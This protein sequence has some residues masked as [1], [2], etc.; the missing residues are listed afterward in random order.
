MLIQHITFQSNS[1][2]VCYL[3]IPSFIGFYILVSTKGKLMNMT[4]TDYMDSL[5]PGPK[6]LIPKIGRNDPPT[7]AETTHP[8]IWPKR[9]KLKR[10]RAETTRIP[11]SVGKVS[12]NTFLLSCIPVRTGSL[13]ASAEIF[14]ECKCNK[15][16]RNVSWLS[17]TSGSPR[18]CCIRGKGLRG[19]V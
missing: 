7:K 19:I 12:G 11:P 16:H 2:H 13:L 6:R 5:D 3:P 4:Q 17:S 15:F 9:P 1:P 18:H 14:S 8:K 10:P